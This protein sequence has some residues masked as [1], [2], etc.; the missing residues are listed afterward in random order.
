M[1][2]K[3]VKFGLFAEDGREQLL[4]GSDRDWAADLIRKHHYTHS[5]PS[6]SSHYVRFC[7][8]IVVWAIPANKN[9]AQ[10]ILGFPGKVWE[11]AR[12]WAPDGHEPNLLTRAISGATNIIEAIERPDALVSYADPRVGHGGGVYRA[13]SWV[14]HGQSDETRSY[15]DSE[16][17]VFPRR[18]FHV[19]KMGMSKAQIEARGFV[20]TKAPGK[21]RFVKYLSRRARATAVD[22]GS[23]ESKA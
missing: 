12:L 7:D 13:A 6:G 17:K 8:A 10:F 9:I 18:A 14:Y 1:R 2:L 16:G 3:D 20:Q 23:R 19:G 5:I 4:I 11:L 22:S 15:L 21:E